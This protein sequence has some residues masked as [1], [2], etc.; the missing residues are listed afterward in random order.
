MLAP[1]VLLTSNFQSENLNL[2]PEI[3]DASKIFD[4]NSGWKPFGNNSGTIVTNLEET[5]INE[6]VADFKRYEAKGEGS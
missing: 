6:A 4:F 3:K 2:K 5:F 1:K